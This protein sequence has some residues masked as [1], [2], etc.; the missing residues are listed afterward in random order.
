MG[1]VNLYLRVAGA[2]AVP[3]SYLKALSVTATITGIKLSLKQNNA[4]HDALWVIRA[5]SDLNCESL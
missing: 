2:A 1:L 4:P 3:L 5:G